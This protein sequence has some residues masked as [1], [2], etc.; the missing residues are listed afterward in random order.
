MISDWTDGD[1]PASVKEE[2]RKHLDQCSFCSRYAES[3]TALKK[4]LAGGCVDCSDA[5]AAVD[6]CV[7]KFL[8]EK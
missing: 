8:S 4:C 2:L 7:R 5:A 1:L 3:L 6:E